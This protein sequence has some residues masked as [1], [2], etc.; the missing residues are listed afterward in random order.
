MFIGMDTGSML[1][2][3]AQHPFQG[4]Q[5]PKY[6]FVAGKQSADLAVEARIKASKSG[7][8]AVGVR[9]RHRVPRQRVHVGVDHEVG[10]R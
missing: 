4:P 5:P 10:S 2:R 9:P 8:V 1:Q 3:I 6:F 7:G